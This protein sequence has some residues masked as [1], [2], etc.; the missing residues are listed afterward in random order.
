MA[1]SVK[2][3]RPAALGVP[4]IAPTE[5]RLKPFGNAPRPM[6]KEMAPVPPRAATEEL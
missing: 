3:K 1:S 4:V 6:L 2:V 5:L